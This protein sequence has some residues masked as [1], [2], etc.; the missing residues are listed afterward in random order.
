MMTHE[1]LFNVG[2][3]LYSPLFVKTFHSKRIKCIAMGIIA[4]GN[5]YL[6]NDTFIPNTELIIKTCRK[7]LSL[8]C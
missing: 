1:L 6:Q 3:S 8:D 7:L 2:G 4:I 5:A